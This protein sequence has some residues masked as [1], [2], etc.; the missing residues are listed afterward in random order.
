MRGRALFGGAAFLAVVALWQRPPIPRVGV[1]ANARSSCEAV[2]GL[3]RMLHISMEVPDR[4]GRLL[5]PDL[6]GATDPSIAQDN[7]DA[8]ICRPGYSRSVRPPYAVTAPLKRR[9]MDAQHP[10]EPM[11]AYER[12]HS[13]PISLGGAPLD[14][15]DLWLEPRQV[16]AN[17]GDKNVL[18]YV[19][20]RL[21]CT[22]QIPL[23]VAQDDIY[24]D[25]AR[26]YPLYAT[27]ANI[28]KFHFRHGGTNPD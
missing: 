18:V 10:G 17:A 26:A 4:A 1:P 15:R 20:W 2:A 7:I 3:S 25:W 19:L 9:M 28:Q 13:I 12:Y 24:H 11:S 22:G 23:K 16:L 6:L 8:V 21:V 5:P 14:A 27:P